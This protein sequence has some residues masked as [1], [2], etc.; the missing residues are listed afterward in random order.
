MK[1]EKGNRWLRIELVGEIDLAWYEDH[2][3]D[4]ERALENRPALVIVDVEHVSFMDSTGLALLAK[5]YRRCKDQCGEVCV[6]YPT[7]FVQRTLGIVGLDQVVTVVTSD[8]DV[9]QIEDRVAAL[10]APANASQERKT[11]ASN[12]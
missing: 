5:A 9:R 2:R 7:P 4:I 11:R 1:F 12:D 3:A 6:I 8:E 10:D